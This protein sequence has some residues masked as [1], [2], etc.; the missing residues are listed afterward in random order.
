S[1]TIV[2]VVA[3]ALAHGR[4]VLMVC[5]KQAATHVVL[6][7]LRSVGLKGLCM[8]VHD[9]ESER[10]AI[11]NEIRN[12]VQTLPNLAPGTTTRARRQKLADQIVTSKRALDRIAA[13]F[14]E[15]N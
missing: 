1:Q 13:A 10:V 14:H 9:P 11:F 2:N 6:E 15:R 3:D 12:Q 5:Q 4:T 8:E 7:R